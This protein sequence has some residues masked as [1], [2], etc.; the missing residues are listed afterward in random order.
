[1]GL[2]R[3]IMRVLPFAGALADRFGAPFVL[4]GYAAA[5]THLDALAYWVV[6]D[7]FEELGRPER[8]FHNG[9]GL[10]TVGNLG[11]PRYWAAHLAAHLGDDVL[12][13]EVTGDGAGRK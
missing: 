7:H 4:S 10:L 1:M 2:R 13:T 3:Y 9:F 8:L 12:A 5:Q 11:K 6:S